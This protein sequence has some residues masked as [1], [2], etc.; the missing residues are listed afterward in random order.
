MTEDEL[1]AHLSEV[2]P[3]LSVHCIRILYAAVELAV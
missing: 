2:R 3:I 1:A